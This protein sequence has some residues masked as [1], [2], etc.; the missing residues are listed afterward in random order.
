MKTYVLVAAAASTADSKVMAH[1]T[2]KRFRNIPAMR[3]AVEQAL[4]LFGESQWEFY[5]AD[6]FCEKWNM[7]NTNSEDGIPSPETTFIAIMEVEHD[8]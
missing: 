4:G 2:G 3:E 1:L 6:Y 5:P 8:E 7:T